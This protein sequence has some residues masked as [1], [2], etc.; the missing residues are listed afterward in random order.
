MYTSLETTG[1]W[2]PQRYER[3]AKKAPQ[4]AYGLY[5][6]MLVVG[7]SIKTKVYAGRIPIPVILTFGSYLMSHVD[8]DY[9][10]KVCVAL[11]GLP[12]SQMTL[13]KMVD[14]SL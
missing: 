4:T 6:K 9:Q 14:I 5:I 3:Y 8:T 11:L 13:V 7:P 1:P 10:M 2:D 12:F